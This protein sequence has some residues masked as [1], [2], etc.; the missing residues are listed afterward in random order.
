MLG[1]LGVLVALGIGALVL[2]SGDDASSATV[3]VVDLTDYTIEGELTV[4]AGPVRLSATNVGAVPH[5]VG[6]R[7]GPISTDLR[8]GG[9]VDLDLGELSPGVYELYCDVADHEARGMI[10]SLEVVADSS[11]AGT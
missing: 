10:A 6:L 5:N 3:V 11:N 7:G 8:P 1:V 2:T 4:A 9:S